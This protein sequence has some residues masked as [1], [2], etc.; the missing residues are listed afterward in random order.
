[1]AHFIHHSCHRVAKGRISGD[2]STGNGALSFPSSCYKFVQLEHFSLTISAN[3]LW[4]DFLYLNNYCEYRKMIWDF[5][6]HLNL[7]YAFMSIG[8]IV[9]ETH[10]HT[11]ISCFFTSFSIRQRNYGMLDVKFY[12]IINQYIIPPISSVSVDDVD[13]F[14]DTLCIEMSFCKVSVKVHI[15]LSNSTIGDASLQSTGCSL[16]NLNI[17]LFQLLS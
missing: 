3:V 4:S 16:S 2:V 8:P 17:A 9:L 7:F 1:M 5:F 12:N 10:T 6:I 15:V 11:H 13:T 14:F